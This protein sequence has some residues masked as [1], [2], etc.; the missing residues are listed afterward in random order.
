MGRP[1]NYKEAQFQAGE[2]LIDII[3][4]L[5]KV[6]GYDNEFTIFTHTE[7]VNLKRAKELLRDAYNSFIH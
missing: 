1:T 5:N 2:L 3:E 6:L 7:L 4:D